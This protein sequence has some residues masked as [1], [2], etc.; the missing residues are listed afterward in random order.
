MSSSPTSPQLPPPIVS[1]APQENSWWT[2]KAPIF[3][4]FTVL[5]AVS[6]LLTWGLQSVGKQVI[7]TLEAQASLPVHKS[8]SQPAANSPDQAQA[9]A[10]LQRVANGDSSAADQVMEQSDRWRGKTQRTARADQL[11]NVS[12]N[13]SDMHTRQASLQAELAMDGV[14]RSQAGLDR[15]ERA[16]DDPSQRA[17]ALWMLGALGNRG[18]DPGRVTGLIASYLTD[19]DANTRASAVDGLSLLATDATLPMLLDRFHN[20]PSPTVQERAACGLAQSG[21][22]THEQRLTAAST[23]V[24]WLDDSQL[25]PQQR[26]WTLQALRDISGQN[27]GTNSSEWQRWLD[28]AR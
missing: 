1:A 24:N 22:F 14:E 7:S 15:A 13:S 6:A 8:N 9:E 23:L 5:L 12:L 2:Q 20:D 25:T 16:L 26:S 10:L 4:F 17:W 28:S 19:S 11:L 21:M 27:L 3:L 18:V